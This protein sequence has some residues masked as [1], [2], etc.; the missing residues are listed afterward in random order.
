MVLEILYIEQSVTFP[1]ARHSN[2]CLIQVYTDP[3]VPMIGTSSTPHTHSRLES[4]IHTEALEITRDS[5]SFRLEPQSSAIRT[6]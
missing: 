4:D 5:S 2:L 3:A 6:F 1:V